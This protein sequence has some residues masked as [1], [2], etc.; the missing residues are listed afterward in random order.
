MLGF[1]NPMLVLMSCQV[2]LDLG[3]K[4]RRIQGGKSWSCAW[5]MGPTCYETLILLV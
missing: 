2:L 5:H 1:I 3:E 4:T